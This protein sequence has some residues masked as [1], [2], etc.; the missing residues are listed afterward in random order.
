MLKNKFIICFLFEFVGFLS[1]S[2]LGEENKSVRIAS[3]LLVFFIV[4]LNIKKIYWL[5]SQDKLIKSLSLFFLFSIPSIFF[6]DEFTKCG[7]KLFDLF[8]MISVIA[9]G[10]LY[11]KTA[12]S[13]VFVFICWYYVFQTIITIIGYFVDPTAI[14][15]E[16]NYGN[17]VTFLHC[18]Y[19][20]I[21]GN[22][23][24]E[25]GAVA[26]LFLYVKFEKEKHLSFLGK[27]AYSIL[28]IIGLSVLYLSSSRTCMIAG[29][30]GFL[31]LFFKLSNSKTK[32]KAIVVC[33]CLSILFSHQIAD[34]VTSI[35]MKKQNDVTLANSDNEADAMVSGRFSIW[36]KALENPHRLILGMGYGVA[37][38]EADIGAANA[39]N[40][41]VE[42]LLNCGVIALLFW[43]RFWYLLLKRYRWLCKVQNLLPIDIAWIHL[44]A[45]IA[46]ISAVRSF[47]NIS[48]VY[49]QLNTFSVIGC[50]ALFEYCR[51]YVLNT[52]KQTICT[53]KFTPNRI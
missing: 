48:F 1:L 30:A 32:I 37:S 3:L 26:F 38:S 13:N 46:A 49:F 31:F 16:G 45:A 39:H 17:Y 40:S 15:A 43:L 53:T 42:I 19:P 10:I 11:F 33:A 21:H 50:V 34:K 36:E 8:V 27:V 35:M 7:F 20:P 22:S 6:C 12:K 23:I 29:L 41:I 24:G 14:A 25:F 9:I 4:L 52:K 28:G 2:F 51:F 47:G 5:L 18:N 44:A